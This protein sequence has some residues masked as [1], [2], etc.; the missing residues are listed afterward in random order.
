MIN[1]LQL[2]MYSYFLSEKIVLLSN[3]NMNL[4]KIT[5]LHFINICHSYYLI[6]SRK[7]LLVYRD[8]EFLFRFSV[9]ACKLEYF[10]AT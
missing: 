7:F 9:L 10:F 8:R 5:A 3:N 1:I 4:P 2:Q 6:I